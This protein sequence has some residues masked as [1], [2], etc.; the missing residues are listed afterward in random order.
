MISRPRASALIRMVACVAAAS[1][2]LGCGDPPAG[3]DAGGATGGE[4]AEVALEPVPA[5]DLPKL[6][7]GRV[8]SADLAG[9]IVVLDFWATWC[10]PCEFQVPGLNA[11]FEA[12]RD[13]PDLVVFGVSVDT[14]GEDVVAEWVAQKDVR[15]PILLDGEPLARRVGALGFPTLLVVTPDG[16]VDEQHVGLIEV[17]TLEAS[18]ARLRTPKAAEPALD[19]DPEAG[20]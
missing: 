1:F 13:E 12:H 16:L 18:L 14:G 17:E 5:F 2:A 3:M 20:S 4:P 19:V 7:G 11:F 10:P 15:Y 8:S 9:K 6:G